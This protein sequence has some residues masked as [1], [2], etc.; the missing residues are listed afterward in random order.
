M[1][2]FSTPKIL[3]KHK[4]AGS[5][6]VVCLLVM[7]IFISLGLGW[8]INSQIF[9][10][11]EG[12]RK[13]NRLTL[14][15]AENGLKTSLELIN[16]QLQTSYCGQE[17][18]EENYESLKARLLSGQTPVTGSAINEIISSQENTDAF[19]RMTWAVSTS[20]ESAGLEDF[21]R[22]VKSTCRLIINSTGRVQGFGGQRT[23]EVA[24]LLTFYA[25][26]LPLDQLSA[27]IEEGGLSENK[28]EQIKLVSSAPA[29]IE[30]D[31][32]LT[33]SQGTIPDDALPLISRGLK[34]LKPDG[35]PNWL[36]RQVLGLPPG[37]D[38]VP[39]GV[40]LIRDDLGL[41]GVF[42]EG[43]LSQLLLGLQADW[44]IIQFQQEDK[45]W[46]MKFNP[47]SQKTSC[48]TPEGRMDDSR[49]LIPLIMIN[50]RVENLAC[51]RPGPDGFLLPSADEDALSILAGCQL[52][53]VSSSDINITTN[54]KAQGLEWKQGIPYLRQKASPL[55]IWSTGKDFQTKEQVDG[56]INLFSQGNQ[57]L[58]ITGNLV[59]G[60]EGLKVNSESGEVQIA[61]SL[62]ATR[63][64]ARDNQLTVFTDLQS[65]VS[66]GNTDELHILANKPLL[67]LSQFKIIEWRVKK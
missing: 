65:Q 7:A 5:A 19:S 17:I 60:G 38:P 46:Q 1:S 24:A 2:F 36:L 23:E 64:K 50:G 11:V 30:N 9:L 41:G 44:Q 18:S 6:F 42:V 32:P 39:D 43:D 15:A 53:I 27:A 3:P 13:L 14:Y 28:N 58:T 34:L 29:S 66:S 49:L 25:G 63:V 55:I 12:S 48:I 56:G 47:K 51:G 21:E 61:G 59:A 10:Q 16:E 62:A 45:T 40:Y 67:H 8:L 52:T 37:N 22:Y 57:P 33:L 31:R 4:E 54:L 35:L 26:H 20:V